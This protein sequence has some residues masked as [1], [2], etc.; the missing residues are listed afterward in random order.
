IVAG[1]KSLPSAV[2]EKLELIKEQKHTCCSAFFNDRCL[3]I[4]QHNAGSLSVSL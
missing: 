2:L 1:D 3:L 4:D